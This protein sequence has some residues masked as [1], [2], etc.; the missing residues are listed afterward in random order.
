MVMQPSLIIGGSGGGNGAPGKSAYEIAVLNGFDGTEQEWLASLQ[1]EDGEPGPKGDAG[2]PG[3]QGFKGD[4]GDKGDAGTGLT[5]RGAFVLGTTY[6]P[7]DYVFATGTAAASSMFISQAAAPFVSVAQPKDDLTHW[8]EFS[9]PA[10]ADGEDGTDGTDGTDGKSVEL[11]KT[12]SA[13]QWRQTGGAWAD[14]FP[15]IEITGPQGPAGDTGQQGP[16]G[17]PGD[18]GAK[19]D[20]GQTGPAGR[21]GIDG[22]NYYVTGMASVSLPSTVTAIR[23]GGYYAPGDGGA[24]LYKKVGTQPSHAGKFQSGDGAWWELCSDGT[25]AAAQFGAKPAV[26]YDN[27]AALNNATTYLVTKFGG[28]VLAYGSGEYFIGAEVTLKSHVTHRGVGI[29]QTIISRLDGY[30]GDML[31]TLDFDTLDAG[32]TA[33]GPNRFGIE[34]L[35][36]NGKKDVAAN[37]SATGWCLRIYGRAYT[38]RDIDIEYCCAGGWYSRWGSTSAAWDNDNTD[39]TMEALIDG[40]RVQFSKGTPTFDGPHDSQLSRIVIAMSRH[41]QA[42]LSGSSTFVIGARAGGS[43]FSGVHCWGNSPE[44]C[45]TNYATGISLMDLVLD[46]AAAGGGLLK[47]IGSECLIVGRGLQYGTDNIQGVQIGQTGYTTQGNKITLVLTATP[48][49]VVAWAIDS[50]NDLDITVNAPTATANFSGN[51]HANSTLKYTERGAGAGAN[52]YLSVFGA[53]V[54]NKQTIKLIPH[55]GTPNDVTWEEGLM[56]YDSSTHKLRVFT[57]SVWVDQS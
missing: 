47:Q 29:R 28:G 45:V 57:G 18:Q 31:K 15:L 19:G 54:V 56:Y 8:V 25:V 32:D 26:A 4:K 48:S 7:S 53:L 11:R 10:G 6:D 52:D 3:P 16:K 44:W 17:N 50:G 30:L 55:S 24:A 5:N 36:I 22:A 21:D 33:G 46:D 20:T 41:N 34:Y 43:Q 1:G 40:L 39:S 2:D 38:L 42:A 37:A 51:R 23:V 27:A 14:L 12:G 49:V 9:A 13:V 35:T